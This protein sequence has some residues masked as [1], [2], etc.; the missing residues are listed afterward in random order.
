MTVRPSEQNVIIHFYLYLIYKKKK[1]LFYIHTKPAQWRK[2]AAATNEKNSLHVRNMLSV[3]NQMSVVQIATMF[4]LGCFFSKTP[5]ALTYQLLKS[6]KVVGVSAGKG[7]FQLFKCGIIPNHRPQSIT[8]YLSFFSFFQAGRT[9]CLFFPGNCSPYYFGA[10][11][12][13]G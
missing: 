7:N 13:V 2:T 11:L 6:K 5:R 10:S 8:L 4:C 3:S 9:P 1:L 12:G